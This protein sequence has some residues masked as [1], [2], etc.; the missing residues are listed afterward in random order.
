MLERCEG[1]KLEIETLGDEGLR[2]RLLQGR[3]SAGRWK[4]LRPYPINGFKDAAGAGD[5]CTAGL[6][7]SLGRHGA[8]GLTNM[9]PAVVED[10]LNLGQALAALK[11][12][13]EGPRGIMYA[14]IKVQFENAVQKT[15]DGGPLPDLADAVDSPALREA[16]TAIC[17]SCSQIGKSKTSSESLHRRSH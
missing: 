8:A 4:E 16:L 13:Y 15:L 12:R 9:S 3:G 10:A 5:W 1:H 6:L 17:P 11:C 2:Y 7:H 14:L